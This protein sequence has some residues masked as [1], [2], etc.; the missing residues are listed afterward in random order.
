MS[1]GNII[2]ATTT[3]H[4]LKKSFPKPKM[5]KRKKKKR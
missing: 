1:I 4:T 2:G 5:R 3:V